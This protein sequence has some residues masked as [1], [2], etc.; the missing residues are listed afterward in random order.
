MSI[1][2]ILNYLALY[3]ETNNYFA[4]PHVLPE[5]HEIANN[6]DVDATCEVLAQDYNSIVSANNTHTTRPQ[7]REQ[8]HG[9]H[10]IC[11]YQRCDLHQECVCDRLYLSS[12]L[13]FKPHSLQ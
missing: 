11:V 1:I 5:T 6:V 2:S 12:V 8:R 7:A 3:S 10:C 13:Y 9:N 4:T